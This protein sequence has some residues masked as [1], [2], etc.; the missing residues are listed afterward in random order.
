MALGGIIEANDTGIM[1]ATAAV[2]G[3]PLGYGTNHK[4]VVLAAATTTIPLAIAAEAAAQN[5]NIGY[6]LPG[7]ICTG[8]AQAAIARNV[9]L[10]ATTGGKFVTVTKGGTATEADYV[11]GTSHSAAGADLDYFEIAFNWY[12]ENLT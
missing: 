7:R 2:M 3:Q 8:L 1:T 10:G 6:W 5:A 9:L 11:W 12:G 4:E